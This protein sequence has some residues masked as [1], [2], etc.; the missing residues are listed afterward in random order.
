MAITHIEHDL[1]PTV[2]F[3]VQTAT[4]EI[5]LITKGKAYL[6]TYYASR[7]LSEI[8][9]KQW[10]NGILIDLKVLQMDV[11]TGHTS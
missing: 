8:K 4:A 7:D 1:K 6:L 5:G 2:E 3:F 9:Q 10:W 11:L